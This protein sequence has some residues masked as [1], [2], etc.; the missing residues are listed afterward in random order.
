[1]NLVF[2]FADQMRA[3][4]CGFDGNSLASTPNFDHLAATG[5]HFS[6]CVSG[7]PVCGPWRGCFFTGQYPL[8]HGIFLNDLRLP[9]DRPTLGTILKQAGY[10]TG[11]IGKW[12]L[13]GADRGGFIPPGPRRQG[14]D[15]WAA[16]NCSHNYFESHYY[17]D[18][19]EPQTW[20]GYDAIAQ[21]DEAIRFIKNASQPFALVMSWGPPHNPYEMVPPEYLDKVPLEKV[22]VP[23]NCPNPDMNDMRG[24]HA[25]ISALDEQIGRLTTT[26]DECGLTDDTI[27]IFTSDHGDMLGSQNHTQ[28]QVPWN[29]S[30]KVPLLIRAPM[31][32][33]A[34]A[35]TQTLFNV[36]DFLP[37]LLGL[38]DIPCPGTVEGL[39]LSEGVRSKIFQGPES[40]LACAIAPFGRYHGRPWRAAITRQHTYARNLKGPWLLYDNIADPFQTHNLVNRPESTALQTELAADLQ[41]LLESAGDDFQ[42]APTHLARFGYEVEAN[43]ARPYYNSLT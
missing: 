35:Q 38:L 18:T 7:T 32:F 6:N 20:S 42:P 21:T 26:L 5:L 28:K 41:R 27:F 43:G 15:F 24:Y 3:G 11:Y 13:D 8:T 30:I 9:T 40:T 39:D 25:H 29:E 37:T 1:M 19:P 36:W 34:G 10:E 31:Q 22:Q 2:V 4:C 33:A 17:R 12:H 14:F 16:A 23:P